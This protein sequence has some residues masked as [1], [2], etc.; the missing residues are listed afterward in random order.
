VYTQLAAW[1]QQHGD[2][3]HMLLFPSDEF[4]GQELPSEQVPAFVEK[5]GLPTDGNGVTLMAKVSK[6]NPR[7]NGEGAPF[8][9]SKPPPLALDP[10]NLLPNLEHFGERAPGSSPLFSPSSL[11]RPCIAAIRTA[12]QRA[13]PKVGV[14]WGGGIGTGGK[15]VK[16]EIVPAGCVAERPRPLIRDPSPY[17]SHDLA[18]SPQR[19]R[20][21]RALNIIYVCIYIYI[22]IYIYI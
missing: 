2:K 7:Q 14:E 11:L 21:L 3:V 20:L 16:T 10:P 6:H 8:F 17:L 12:T 9:I 4:G 5:Q 22:Y 1:H 13:K 19:R 15:R 18:V